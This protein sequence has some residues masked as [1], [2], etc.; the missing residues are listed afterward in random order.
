[1][2]AQ[3][4]NLPPQVV[5]RLAKEVRKLVSFPPE[6]VKFLATEEENLGEVHAEIEGPQGTPYEG[7]FFE[8]KL[9]LGGDFPNSPPRGF[10]LSKIYHP[11][12]NPTS[13]DICVNTLKK[14]WSSTTTISHV[15][16]VIRCLLIVPFPE[17]SLNDEAGKLFMDSYDEYARRAR[18]MASV[19][20]RRS[21]SAAAAAADADDGP[22]R[23]DDAATPKNDKGRQQET[24][25]GGGGVAGAG[26]GEGSKAATSSSRRS[27]QGGGKEAG[28]KKTAADADKKKAKKK[29]NINRL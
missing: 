25:A 8:L 12:V 16:S 19:H 14:D 29:K 4:E 7:Y 10:F 20:A 1:M 18:L 11:N 28:R 3:A 2:A 15:L 23:N 13:G 21:S 27:E 5:V 22:G 26:K 9:V 6:G 24:G 17:S